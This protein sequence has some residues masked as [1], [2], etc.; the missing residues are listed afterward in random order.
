MEPIFFAS[1][2][3]WRAW[4]A[5]HHATET[6]VWVGLYK[7][8][9]NPGLTWE[10][11]VPEALCFG[12]I[13]GVV[14]RIDADSHQ[15]RFTPRKRTSKWSAVNVRLIGELEA[16]GKMTAAGR[17]AFEARDPS[18]VPYSV[19]MRPDTFPPEW[20]AQLR[21]DPS[22]AAYWDT[23]PPS[24]RKQYV[25][26]VTDAKREQTREKQFALLLQACQEK[27]RLR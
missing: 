3:D 11:A 6:H 25:F 4:L 1:P 7:K 2:A 19:S 13:D 22:A 14:R 15:Q 18:A 21:S 23:C 26:W 24:Y 17:A 10:T 5:A 12:W 8:H 9:L 20:E 16:A 27:G